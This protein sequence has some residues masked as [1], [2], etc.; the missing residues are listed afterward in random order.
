MAMS[1]QQYLVCILLAASLTCRG[2][3]EVRDS[4]PIKQKTNQPAKVANIPKDAFWIGGAD[5]G[6]WYLIG[7]IDKQAKTVQFKIY[8]DYDG[9][10][11]FDKYFKLICD[12]DVEVDLT[13]LQTQI[14][15]FDGSRILL[16]STNK[17]N[18]YCYFE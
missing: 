6:Q 7:I 17:D 15:T 4:V 13:T 18:K 10:L 16:I 9:H 3:M 12:S 8:N 2:Q 14:N 5:G 1:F 11:L